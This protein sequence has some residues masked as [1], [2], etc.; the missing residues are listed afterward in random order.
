MD[1]HPPTLGAAMGDLTDD[2]PGSVVCER[3]SCANRHLPPGSKRYPM[4]NPK[5]Q[6]RWSCEPCI[7]RK[8]LEPTTYIPESTTYPESGGGYGGSGRGFAAAAIPHHP[9]GA[10]PPPGGLGHPGTINHT[11]I[12]ENTNAGQRDSECVALYRQRSWLLTRI[13]IM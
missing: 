12:R 5:G 9:P 2:T 8:R 10:F 13:C 6:V 11:A 1:R 7:R 4:K 3:V